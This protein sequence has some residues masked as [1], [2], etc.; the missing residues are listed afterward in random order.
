MTFYGKITLNGKFQLLFFY[1]WN[2]PFR[3]D[4]FAR[5]HIP[6]VYKVHS[7]Q[8]LQT[9]LVVTAAAVNFFMYN[10]A[11]AANNLNHLNNIARYD[12]PHV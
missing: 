11:A 2:F 7:Q 12:I 8:L 1:R 3:V 9:S 5:Y 10:F 6:H 4:N